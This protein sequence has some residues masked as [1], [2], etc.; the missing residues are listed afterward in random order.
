[1]NVLLIPLHIKYLDASQY[2]V[3]A[4]VLAFGTFVAL[5]SNMKLNAAMQVKFFEFIPSEGHWFV[6]SLFTFTLLG[7]AVVFLL[8]L[9]VGDAVF[10]LLFFKNPIAFYPLGQLVLLSALVQICTQVRL[11]DLK[12]QYKLKTLA[13]YVIAE[14]SIRV[15]L[16]VFFLSVM[17]MGI[18]GI[19]LGNLIASSVLLLVAIF[20]DRMLTIR[21]NSIWIKDSLKFT[22]PLLPYALMEALLPRLGKYFMSINLELADVGIYSLIIAVT[23]LTTIIN[24]SLIS[25]IRPK[26]YKSLNAEKPNLITKIGEFYRLYIIAGFLGLYLLFMLATNFDQLLEVRSEFHAIKKYIG[27]GLI[28]SVP[29]FIISISHMELMFLKRPREVTLL[30][31]IKFFFVAGLYYVLIPL[32]GIW[33]SLAAL[34]IS[35]VLNMII[36]NHTAHKFMS[37]NVRPWKEFITLSVIFVVS[38]LFY[39]IPEAQTSKII[40][41]SFFL[42]IIIIFCFI[43]SKQNGRLFHRSD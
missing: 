38:I 9:L 31:S 22:I 8:F 40:L 36:F 13:K 21:I 3:L 17:E 42:I 39:H 32:Y 7:S 41:Q 14:N 18:T 26:V 4:L 1:M 37:I 5:F 28:S 27:F 35:R 12:N 43:F 6:R 23:G 2:G 16:Q 11:I 20:Y 10:Q 34:V 25:T 33:G 30:T 24:G 15:L 19:I 29:I